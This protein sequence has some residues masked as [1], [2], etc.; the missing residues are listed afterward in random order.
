ME[1]GRY[2][3]AEMLECRVHGFREPDHGNGDY[4]PAPIFGADV[5][6]EPRDADEDGGCQMQ[7]RI[8]LCPEHEGESGNRK[9]KTFHA[10]AE[11]KGGTGHGKGRHGSDYGRTLPV[12]TAS[13]EIES[14]LDAARGTIRAGSTACASSGRRTAT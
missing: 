8:V 9:A 2:H 1:F 4:E 12:S 14:K 6:C 3:V 13:G 10:G 7:P 11:G 5:E